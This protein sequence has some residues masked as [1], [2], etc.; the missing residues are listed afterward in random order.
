MVGDDRGAV[1]GCEGEV[2]AICTMIGE[3]RGNQGNASAAQLHPHA[4]IRHDS[5]PSIQ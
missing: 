1:R 4:A 5:E 3:E 2:T